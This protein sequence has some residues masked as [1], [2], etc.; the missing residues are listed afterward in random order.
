MSTTTTDGSQVTTSSLLRDIVDFVERLQVDVAT[1]ATSILQVAHDS[2]TLNNSTLEALQ[3]ISKRN[4]QTM[5][6]MN[7]IVVA[8]NNLQKRIEV[9]EQANRLLYRSEVSDN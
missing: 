3:A 7:Q 1:N 9:L 5:D 4:L 6:M 8:I 2:T